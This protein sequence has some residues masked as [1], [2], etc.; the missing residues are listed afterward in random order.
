MIK[1]EKT[2]SRRH[3]SGDIV[4]SYVFQDEGGK[5]SVQ[6]SEDGGAQRA[7]NW[8]SVSLSRSMRQARWVA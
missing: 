4:R 5:G 3:G 1:L 8:A 6:M 2:T 7:R